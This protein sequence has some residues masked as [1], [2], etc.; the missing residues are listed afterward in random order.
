MA[1]TFEA[2]YNSF[3]SKV[4]D[5]DLA[6]MLEDSASAF[7]FDLLK[8]AVA[9]LNSNLGTTSFEMNYAESQFTADLTDLEIDIISEIMV[10]NWLKPKLN[11]SELLRNRLSTKD[12]SQFSPANLLNAVRES[13][14]LA[15]SRSESLI[16]KYTFMVND[17]RDLI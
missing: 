17:V 11:N 9:R 1:T 6:D 5:F 16:N 10:E 12:F 8:Q 4:T 13:F 3:Y 2:I 14:N 7:L 15:H